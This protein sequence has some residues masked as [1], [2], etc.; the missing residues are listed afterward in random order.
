MT[1]G[2]RTQL[3]I[4]HFVALE[5]VLPVPP[6]SSLADSISSSAAAPSG[7][8]RDVCT[9][10]PRSAVVLDSSSCPNASRVTAK[11]W[12]LEKRAGFR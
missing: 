7:P 4:P 6:V 1:E 10:S 8:G 2:S 5:E 11:L 9:A 3:R 12:M